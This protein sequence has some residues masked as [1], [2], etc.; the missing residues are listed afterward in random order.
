MSSLDLNLS[1]VVLT[2][3]LRTAPL[4]GATSSEDY[5]DSQRENLVDLAAV[6]GFINNTLL[7]L[8]NALPEGT[9]QPVTSPVGLEGRTIWGDTS[10]QTNLFFDALTATP[11][12][13]ADAIRSVSAIV[14]VMQ[15][16]LTDQGI[17]VATLQT[18]LASTNQ[19]DI[20]L[21]LQNLS[22]SLNQISL[23][24][25]TQTSAITDLQLTQ[26]FT[27]RSGLTIVPPGS[28]VDI[29]VI[30]ASPLNDD[31]YTAG[32]FVEVPAG[33]DGLVTAGAFQKIS[34]G[35]GL[36]VPVTNFDST[37]Q[38]AIVHVL[39][40]T[41]SIA[42][43]I[44]N[45]TGEGGFS[46]GEI[47]LGAI[48]GMNATF[49]LSAAPFPTASLQLYLNGLLMQSGGGDYSLTGVVITF[50]APPSAGY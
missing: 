26:V 18:R 3:T 22:S 31:F 17:E 43:G 47:P 34:V 49:T 12:S 37:V 41:D 4:N 45:P 23:T 21:A 16:Q 42:G 48:D 7:P 6:V 39:A 15:Q 29:T 44:G 28:T 32:V 10:D 20:A 5:N 13:I 27:A 40:K 33:P 9:L 30:F 46:D 38:S 14:T 36:I 50:T 2:S 24:Q 1:S 35:I 11:L 8:L 19:N 25:Q